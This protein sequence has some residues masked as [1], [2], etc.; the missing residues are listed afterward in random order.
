[1]PRLAVDCSSVMGGGTL[2]GRTIPSAGIA[3]DG[4]ITARLRAATPPVVA[5]VVEGR[6]ICDLR[7]VRPDQDPLLAKALIG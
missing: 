1:M 6:T 5:R 4:D 3:V 7:T 2:P